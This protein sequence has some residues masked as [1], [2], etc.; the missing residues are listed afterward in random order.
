MRKDDPNSTTGVHK[1]I[2]IFEHLNR[3]E[4]TKTGTI[5]I[6]STIGLIIAKWT[7]SREPN[8]REGENNRG[9]EVGNGSM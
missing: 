4:I 6:I 1:L 8:K 5:N 3:A 9:R 2:N 7:Y